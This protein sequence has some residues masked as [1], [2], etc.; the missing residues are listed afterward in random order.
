MM[1]AAYT[2]HAVTVAMW[3]TAEPT[4]DVL[5]HPGGGRVARAELRERVALQPGD[6]AGQRE[7]DPDGRAG[8]LAGGAQQRE[9]AGTDHGADTDER[10]LARADV[11]SCG[12]RWRAGADRR[13]WMSTPT[14]R[15]TMH[16]TARRMSSGKTNL[17]HVPYGTR[18]MAR[19]PMTTAE[20]GVMRLISPFPAW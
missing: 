4:V 19:P 6:R 13:H 20:V 18:A 2:S 3:P 12:E 15:T 11:R 9:D 16:S 8:H 17:S 5:E 7:R 10:R 1:F 14:D